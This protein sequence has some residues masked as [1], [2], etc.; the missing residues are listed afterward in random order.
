[1]FDATKI[2]KTMETNVKTEKSL[3]EMVNDMMDAVDN[4]KRLEQRKSRP[5]KY[6]PLGAYC[7]GSIDFENMAKTILGYNY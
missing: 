3:F 2:T 7:D 5:I 6:N 4:L 1:M